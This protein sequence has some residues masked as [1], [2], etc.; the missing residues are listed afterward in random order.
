MG[1]GRAEQGGKAPL[2]ARREGR[3]GLGGPLPA[4][5]VVPTHEHLT[6]PTADG[7]VGLVAVVIVLV[8]TLQEAVLESRV[9]GRTT[10]QGLRQP[11]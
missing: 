1:L 10:R 2:R 8:R 4:A 6:P 7:A 3:Y 9:E 11:G 5:V